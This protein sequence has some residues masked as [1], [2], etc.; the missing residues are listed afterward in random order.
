MKHFLFY[1]RDN[2]FECVA[3]E[4]IIEAYAANSLL[5]LAP[6]NNALSI[7]LSSPEAQRLNSLMTEPVEVNEAFVRSLQ[8]ASST[9][10]VSPKIQWDQ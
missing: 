10:R 2:T 5:S 8:R 9:A 1:F 6:L 7:K 3:R 4:C